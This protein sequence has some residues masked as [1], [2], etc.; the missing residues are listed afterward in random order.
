M[1]LGLYSNIFECSLNSFNLS[2][3][4]CN[5]KLYPE[6]ADLRKKIFEKGIK[7][8]IYA[9]ENKIYGYGEDL[10]KLYVYDFHDINIDLLEIPQL[11]RRIIFNSLIKYL[12]KIGMDVIIKKSEIRAYDKSK[13]H[14]LVEKSL[15]LIK[16]FII[17]VTYFYDYDL[18]R[19]SFVIIVDT[20]VI[21]SDN[22]GK[23]LNF[24]EIKTNF[25]NSVI[26]RIKKIQ[27]EYLPN[28]KINL[29]ISKLK[30]NDEIIP[31]VKDICSFEGIMGIK[32][33]ISNKPIH[34]TLGG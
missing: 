14:T 6:L 10:S 33:S 34:I 19:V 29:E 16:G 26:Y 7:V 8:E 30:L 12:R 17:K 24:H 25:G 13:K 5:R 31:F 11:T 18:Q 32:I 27:N 4:S 1:E 20:H 15:Y 21:I 23:H 9:C 2:I 28:N 22:N 3:V